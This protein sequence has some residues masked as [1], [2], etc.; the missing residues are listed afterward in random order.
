MG[1]WVLRAALLCLGGALVYSKLHTPHRDGPTPAQEQASKPGPEAGA[2]EEEEPFTKGSISPTVLTASPRDRT[3]LLP[4][5]RL[6]DKQMSEYSW[7]KGL[8]GDLFRMQPRIVQPVKWQEMHS[9]YLLINHNFCFMSEIE[10][11]ASL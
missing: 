8:L 4:D 3:Q 5:S 7:P 11:G 1:S 2:P 10:P 9:L 6:I